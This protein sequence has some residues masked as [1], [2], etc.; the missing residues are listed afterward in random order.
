MTRDRF[1]LRFRGN[2]QAVVMSLRGQREANPPRRVKGAVKRTSAAQPASQS[3]GAG[4]D[5]AEAAPWS[6]GLLYYSSLGHG[7]GPSPFYPCSHR[8]TQ[9]HKNNNMY[10]EAWQ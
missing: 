1:T 3:E 6:L 10:V 2:R 5:G 9:T 4:S 7:G 8:Q